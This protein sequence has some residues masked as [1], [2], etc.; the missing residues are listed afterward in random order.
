MSYAG[1][2]SLMPQSPTPKLADKCGGCGANRAKRVGG[3]L[4]CSYC[5]RPWLG[6]PIIEKTQPTNTDYLTIDE[7]RAENGLRPLPAPMPGSGESITR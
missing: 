3:V 1:A 5:Q 2:A 4:E 7:I 6:G